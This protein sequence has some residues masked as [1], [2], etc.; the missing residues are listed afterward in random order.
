MATITAT[1]AAGTP[2]TVTYN[3]LSGH[4][5]VL[6]AVADAHAA[7]TGIPIVLYAHGRGGTYNQFQTLS[8]WSGL[9]DWLIDNGWA[10]VEGTGGST[11]ANGQ[12]NWGN[13]GARA[14][15]AAYFDHVDGILDLG[16]LVILGRSMGG[17]IA[18]YLAT[19]HPTL[20]ARADGLILNSGVVGLAWA[21]APASGFSPAIWSSY[22]AADEAGFLAA[23][24]EYD[25]LTFAASVWDGRNVLNLVGTADTTV[26]P[27]ENG[28]ALRDVY[29]GRPAIDQLDVRDG[30]DHSGSNGSYLQVTAMSNFL[31]EVAGEA[32]PPP[33]DPVGYRVLSAY[34][35]LDGDRYPL[36]L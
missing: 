30:G 25:P 4:G 23:I 7:D 14:A 15:Y 18:S 28:L 2:Y 33:A 16:T 20:A 35:M 24:T 21:G 6:W 19:R 31:L 8:A 5:T 10:W 29:V 34:L 17:V 32:V 26:P 22:G 9:R 1:T 3:T 13:A 12:E 27:D 11:T 36:T